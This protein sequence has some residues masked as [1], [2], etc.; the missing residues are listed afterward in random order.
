MSA[1]ESLR[2]EFG[3]PGIRLAPGPG[4]LTCVILDHEGSHARASLHGA[5]VLDYQPHQ[6][7]EVL[8]LSPAAILDSRQAIRGGVPICWPWFGDHPRDTSL[9][10]HGFARINDWTLVD[11]TSNENEKAVTLA[12]HDNAC[13]RELWPHA[14]EL[15]YRLSLS[16]VL[17]ASLCV[18]NTGAANMCFSA[19]LH[20]Y[21]S[22]SAIG[23]TA[24]EG[25]AGCSYLD[26]P[27]NFARKVQTER[28]LRFA[29]E[30]DRIY[31]DTEADCTVHDGAGARRIHIRKS[32]SRS[33]VV[34]NPW[35]D[36]AARF[37]D[38]PDDGYRGMLCVETAN[39]ASDVIDLEPGDCHTLAVS[40]ESVA[41][42]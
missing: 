1:F 35:R 28:L 7:A 26:K 12:L 39:A 32:G 21:F 38:F 15:R 31:L 24:L 27:D 3:K 41:G 30:T 19:A 10:A 14:F 11:S 36:R 29:A 5:H 22:V 25:L 2:R 40:V 23:Q 37:D 6:Q 34:W 42:A 8:W 16:N 9:P 17:R 13:T 18:I 33:T 4:D 20:S